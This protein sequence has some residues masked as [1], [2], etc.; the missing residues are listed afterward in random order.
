MTELIRK[1]KENTGLF[2]S[3]DVEEESD[4]SCYII[5]Q[6]DDRKSDREDI[7]K[8]L[9]TIVSEDDDYSLRDVDTFPNGYSAWSINIIKEEEN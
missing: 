7:E 4:D 8:F 1:I 3:V 5:V 6:I 9:K 2:E